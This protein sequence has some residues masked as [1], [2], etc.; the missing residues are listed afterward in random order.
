[1]KT[2]LVYITK[3][4]KIH[5]KVERSQLDVDNLVEGCFLHR[6]LDFAGIDASNRKDAIKK[7]HQLKKEV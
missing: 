5:T 4:G 6:I 7:F 2:Y 1:M 3:D